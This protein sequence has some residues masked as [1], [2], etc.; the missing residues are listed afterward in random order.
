VVVVGGGGGGSGLLIADTNQFAMQLATESEADNGIQKMLPF[1]QC[2]SVV[3]ATHCCLYC[4]QHH[5]ELAIH[6]PIEQ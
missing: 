5:P 4:A 1:A 6:C 3:H 2:K